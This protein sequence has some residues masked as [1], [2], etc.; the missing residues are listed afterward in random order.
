MSYISLK[1]TM[2]CFLILIITLDFNLLL[3]S[4][5]ECSFVGLE[6]SLQSSDA[7]FDVRSENLR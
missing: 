5:F 2:V 6:C 3:N 1:L 4:Y 7:C